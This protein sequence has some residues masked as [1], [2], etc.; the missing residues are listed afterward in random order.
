MIDRIPLDEM[1]SD[2]LD[3]LWNQIDRDTAAIAR[4]RALA[5]RW[6][7][8]RAYGSAA[9]E[10]RTAL[11]EQPGPAATEPA[12]TASALRARLRAAIDPL[13]LEHPEHNRTDEHEELLGEIIT[14]VLDV[15]LPHGRFMRAMHQSAEEDVSRVITLYEHWVKAGPPPLGTSLSRWWDA[16]LVE[17]HDAILP[18][19]DQP[20]E[21]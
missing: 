12:H 1:N 19:T 11:D 3:A 20:K 6:G 2:Q 17:L 16:R 14:G 8:L 13:L 21:K 5:S 4:A 18:P 15:V 10:L 7:I 9:T